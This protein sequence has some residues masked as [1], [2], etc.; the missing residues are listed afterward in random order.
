MRCVDQAR[1]IMRRACSVDGLRCGLSV[2]KL[3][4]G[5][6]HSF[7]AVW[8]GCG[9]AMCGGF[10]KRGQWQRRVEHPRHVWERDLVLRGPTDDLAVPFIEK[11][12]G[13]WAAHFKHDQARQPHSK[14]VRLPH[15]RV[16]RALRAYRAEEW[17]ILCVSK[18]LFTF[19]RQG[20]AS[21]AIVHRDQAVPPLR[22]EARAERVRQLN[23][24]VHPYDE[25]EAPHAWHTIKL[26]L[27]PLA[28]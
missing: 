28:N 24:C 22:D 25:V 15:V 18:R 23:R 3:A 11:G 12:S 14:E 4:E 17:F 5:A 16:A 27:V 8:S 7:I 2:S 20:A 1:S 21:W 9:D 13:A 19:S 6:R 10:N 26:R